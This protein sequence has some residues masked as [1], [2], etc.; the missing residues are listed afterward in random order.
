MA[1]QSARLGKTHIADL[2]AEGSYVGVAPEVHDQARA[3]VENGIA[4]WVLAHEVHNFLLLT[5]VPHLH[6]LVHVLWHLQK[7]SVR[8]LLRCAVDESGFQPLAL[9]MGPGLLEGL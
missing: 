2:A 9:L 6:L 3:L 8:L 1:R 4:L 7:P 5:R